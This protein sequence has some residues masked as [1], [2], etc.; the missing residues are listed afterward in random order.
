MVLVDNFR[1]SLRGRC[2]PGAGRT[3]ADRDG[4]RRYAS[5][6]AGGSGPEGV[7]TGRD[8]VEGFLRGMLDA[9]IPDPQRYLRTAAGTPEQAHAVTTEMLAL[10]EPPTALFASDSRVALGALRA[11]RE[12]PLRVPEDISLV[13]FDDADWTGVVTPS[14]TV[15]SQPAQALGYRAGE[16]LIGRI[17]GSEEPAQERA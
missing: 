17:A 15:V 2:P 1:A 5:V 14:V 4:Y 11:I 16:I 8:R 6:R 9:G 3:P 13:A 7:S 12:A 10:P